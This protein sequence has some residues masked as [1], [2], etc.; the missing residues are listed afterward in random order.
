MNLLHL[1]YAVEVEKTGSI[2]QA[3]ENLFMGQP[4]LSKAIK[5]LEAALGMLIF[6]RTSKGVVATPKGAE[7]LE[8]ARAILSQIDAIEQEYRPHQEDRVR[9]SVCIPRASY[10]AYAFAN[11]VN[12][13]DLGKELDVTFRETN[14]VET[15]GCVARGEFDVG[16]IRF[17]EQYEKYFMN[18]MVEK[19]LQ[20]EPICSFEKVI[21]LDHNHPLAG[22]EVISAEDLS[23]YIEITHGDH[24]VPYLSFNDIKEEEP[25]FGVRRIRIYERGSQFCLLKR[26]PGSFMWVSPMPDEVLDRHALVQRRCPAVPHTHR[27]FLIYQ[28]DHK[29]TAHEKAFLQAVC[30]VRD[31]LGMHE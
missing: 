29:L 8:K 13:L 1:K 11:F 14:S 22:Q 18:Q 21:L 4:N 24:A 3:A 30:D 25:A 19:G 26:V 20:Y 2:T 12:G 6:K 28:K 31:A 16:I 5:E 9:F 23:P 10:I 17:R 27:D 7:F 15:V